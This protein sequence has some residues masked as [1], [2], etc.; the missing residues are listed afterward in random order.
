MC[1]FFFL[2]W[3]YQ[4]FTRK[5]LYSFAACDPSYYQ[6]YDSL[7]TAS[8]SIIN[9]LCQKG[10]NWETA[11]MC[12]FSWAFIVHL[13]N[14]VMNLSY[15]TSRPGVPH[16]PSPP[17]PLSRWLSLIFST[18]NRSSSHC[19]GF[20]SSSGHMWDKP[21]SACGW[22]GG[23]SWG[24]PVFAPSYDWLGSKWVK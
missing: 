15:R 14:T 11:W 1:H 4:K 20:E 13:C 22:S 7:S 16:L 10:R 9:C 3:W 23:F 24:S 17:P 18:L 19:C 6:R 12:R 5:G 8:C 21:S 2:L